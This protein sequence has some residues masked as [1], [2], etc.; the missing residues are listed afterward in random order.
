M[1]AVHACFG[2]EARGGFH[3]RSGGL[4]HR[5]TWEHGAGPRSEGTNTFRRIGCT[6]TTL[7]TAANIWSWLELGPH[8]TGGYVLQQ[9]A[10]LNARRLGA[11]SIAAPC[12][13][14][15]PVYVCR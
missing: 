7:D 12:A 8:R 14:R 2:H 11:L 1:L 5:R 3:E 9:A 6:W 10:A 4:A 13:V 15:M